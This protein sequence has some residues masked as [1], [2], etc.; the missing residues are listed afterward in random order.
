MRR[1][2]SAV[3]NRSTIAAAA[4]EIP[5]NTEEGR[6]QRRGDG[7]PEIPGTQRGS[8]QELYN[9][10]DTYISENTGR[11]AVKVPPLDHSQNQPD[12]ISIV[13]NLTFPEVD[14]R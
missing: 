2:E 5:E 12:F 1:G 10:R 13:P 11:G 14:D 8:G 9:T 7:T 3:S 4:S 6:G